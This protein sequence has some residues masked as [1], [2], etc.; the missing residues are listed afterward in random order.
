MLIV[1]IGAAIW[2]GAGVWIV[3]NV[4]RSAYDRQSRPFL[5]DIIVGRDVHPVGKYLDDWN[6]LLGKGLVIWLLIGAA[7]VAMAQ[8]R[9]RQFWFGR[10]IARE[11]GDMAASGPTGSVLKLWLL[12]AMA[13]LLLH[14]HE[15][16]QSDMV[17][18]ACLY[19]IVLLYLAKQPALVAMLSALKP[20]RRAFLTTLIAMCFVV[21][22]A[23]I[24]KDWYP[25]V[26]WPMYAGSRTADPRYH[27]FTAVRADGKEVA[28]RVVDLLR[29][30]R[31]LAVH[32][33]DRTLDRIARTPQGPN[34]AAA[35]DRLQALLE[36]LAARHNQR[37]P[38]DS[39]VA[40]RIWHCTIP[41]A[42]YQGRQSIE[43]ELLREVRV[44]QR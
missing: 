42:T 8:P 3:P 5:N 13:A 7:A 41:M 24:P 26:T 14:L 35:E 25:L 18:E 31:R 40:I 33:L 30:T 16:V 11:S 23:N 27:E 37:N 28:F 12:I 39:I 15:Y 43:R 2:L 21:Q 32:M 4:I 10:S 17:V 6:M 19:G 34:R 9:F 36:V 38:H 1:V 20:W 22:I 44:D 29:T